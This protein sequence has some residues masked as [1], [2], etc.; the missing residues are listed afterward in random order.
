MLHVFDV[1]ARKYRHT[2]YASTV[3][4]VL[5]CADDL[6]DLLEGDEPSQKRLKSGDDDLSLDDGDDMKEEAYEGLEISEEDD[7]NEDDV[8]EDDNK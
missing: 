4:T 3:N 8:T 2:F 6:N 1:N 5:F 7:N